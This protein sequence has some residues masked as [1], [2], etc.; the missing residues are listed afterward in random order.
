MGVST[1]LSSTCKVTHYTL[2]QV[3]FE[4]VGA[5]SGPTPFS[6]PNSLLPLFIPDFSNH[7]SPKI[8][9]DFSNFDAGWSGAGAGKFSEFEGTFHL[10]VLGCT[11]ATQATTK[12]KDFTLIIKAK[13]NCDSPNVNFNPY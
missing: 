13:I 4:P 8:T 1:D 3:Q 12:C 6:D 11:S 5:S 2:Q 9:A 7:A 10:K